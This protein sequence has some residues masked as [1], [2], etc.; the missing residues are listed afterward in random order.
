[1]PG[2]VYAAVIIS[3]ATFLP[4]SPEITLSAS[5]KWLHRTTS[6]S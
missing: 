5:Q 3:S 4:G 6:P 1:M 2:L